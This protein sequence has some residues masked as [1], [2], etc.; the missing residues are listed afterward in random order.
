MERPHNDY[1]YLVVSVGNSCRPA[2]VGQ[3]G[4]RAMGV[5]RVWASLFLLLT[6]LDAAP[7]RGPRQS[8][9]RISDDDDGG[10]PST[11]PM[12]DAEFA[13]RLADVR[14]HTKRWTEG[15]FEIHM[16]EVGQGNSQLV[17]FP[18]GFTILIDVAENSWNTARGAQLVAAK[19]EAIL[20]HTHVNIGSPSHWHL[21][22]LGY[23]GY[24]GF[25]YLITTGRV[26]FDKIIDRD[27]AQWAGEGPCPLPDSGPLGPET[28]EQFDWRN[29]GTSGGT[30]ERWVCW[31]TD[32]RNEQI[33]RLREVAVEGFD[34]FNPPDADSSVE[35]IITDAIGVK[36]VDGETPVSGDQRFWRNASGAILPPSENDY[37]IALVIRHGNFSYF[38]GG[39]LDG[40]Y[41]VSRFGYTYNDVETPIADRV[42]QV[43]LFQVNHHG[44][45][46]STNQFFIDTVRP[47]ASLI[48]CGVDNSH[49]HPAQVVLNRV[50][51]AGHVYLHHVCDSSRDYG[52]SRFVGSDI[53]I[54]SSD[55]GA[56]FLVDDIKYTSRG[57]ARDGR[58]I[59]TTSVPPCDTCAECC[60]SYIPAGEMCDQC[61]AENCESRVDAIESRS[62]QQQ[63][64]DE[65]HQGLPAWAPG[66]FEVRVLDV[67]RGDAQLIV[68][69]SGFS[70]L[71]DA[72]E[73]SWN[74]QVGA[75]RIIQAVREILG[76][77][78]V[79]VAVVTNWRTDHVGYPGFGGFFRLIEGGGVTFD[80]V[81]DRAG[82]EWLGDTACVL[83]ETGAPSDEQMDFVR[84]LNAG[85]TS[86][87]AER[88]V[89][90]AT[91]PHSGSR[92]SSL[93]EVAIAGS[94]EQIR[95]PDAEAEVLIAYVDGNGVLLAD[96]VTPLSGDRR[97]G[98]GSPPIEQDY[99]LALRIKFGKFTYITAGDI[100][101]VYENGGINNVEAA[102]AS[103]IGP[104]DVMRANNYGAATANTEAYLTALLPQVALLNCG[105]P[106]AGS[107][108]A[109][110]TLDRLLKVSDVYLHHHCNTNADYGAAEVLGGELRITSSDGGATFL[111]HGPHGK[112]WEYTSGEGGTPPSPPPP[113]PPAP[114]WVCAASTPPCNTCEAC[115]R[116]YLPGDACDACVRIECGR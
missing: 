94:T 15:Q 86:V 103:R 92:M 60:H 42:G 11:D 64:Q 114:G 1:R 28:L 97:Y 44:S 22:H 50:L 3:E 71:V 99:S 108:P 47:Q 112:G 20:G 115:C 51:A 26:T 18:S 43:D 81:V 95:P 8:A 107:T 36:M 41:N 52:S 67:G 87:T 73:N 98:F 57:G 91:D 96:G 84:W 34:Q 72:P 35:V 111:L 6:T 21:D 63:L 24:G 80:K 13:A 85:V 102:V 89:C 75:T 53:V 90:W 10:D 25:W 32:P 69:P 58:H 62:T 109:Q 110:Q 54:T 55:G 30:G 27:G 29:V 16:F 83:P 39:D 113:P 9:A 56:T 70:I 23:V 66:T 65:V 100:N 79:N 105:L 12:S 77:T 82:A 4:G 45:S 93:R 31:A 37:C 38:T 59:C 104:V 14:E 78:H 68:F 74:S 76:H 116:D 46:H 88:W 106:S 7:L 17:I 49:G 40:S 101:G 48:S 2:R 61:V 5:L 19:V 33:Y